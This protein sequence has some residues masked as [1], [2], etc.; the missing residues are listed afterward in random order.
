MHRHRLRRKNPPVSLRDHSRR[1]ERLRWDGLGGAFYV[2]S[3]APGIQR[4]QRIDRHS[5]SGSLRRGKLFSSTAGTQALDREHH[6]ARDGLPR[7]VAP[8]RQ[9]VDLKLPRS[10]P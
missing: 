4:A 6:V 5:L 3:C 9:L 8:H 1:D 10:R 7:S 2:I